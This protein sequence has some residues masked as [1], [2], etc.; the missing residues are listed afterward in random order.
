M[1]L[2]TLKQRVEAVHDSGNRLVA[3]PTSGSDVLDGARGGRR[4]RDGPGSRRSTGTKHLHTA[5]KD[6]T[7]QRD[8]IL[9]RPLDRSHDYDASSL[10]DSSDVLTV[11]RAPF[12]SDDID[13]SATVTVFQRWI[14]IVRRRQACHRDDFR[15]VRCLL[16]SRPGGNRPVLDTL[17]ERR[18]LPSVFLT[19][20]LGFGLEAGR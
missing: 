14:G 3:S 5:T 7:A 11:P 16:G 17:R 1:F 2:A 10:S 9:Y 18:H 12:A 8:S 20:S 6:P 13:S 19:S 15:F 4:V